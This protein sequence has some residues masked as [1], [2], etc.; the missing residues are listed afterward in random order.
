M[1]AGIRSDLE[2]WTALGAELVTSPRVH[3]PSSFSALLASAV[4]DT[5]GEV[6]VDTGCGAGLVT[7][8]A[9]MADAQH[10]IA[11]DYDAN[12]L[13]D[14][15]ANVERL[16][17]PAARQRLTLWE[18]DWRQ[19]GPMRADV[20]AV[21]PPQRPT[22]LLEDVDDDVLHLHDGGGD[23]GFAG[24]RMVLGHAGT[25]RVRT[26][27]AAVLDLPAAAPDLCGSRWS[28]PSVLTHAHLPLDPAWH[29]L[30]P[31]LIGRVDVWEFTRPPPSHGDG[32][33]TW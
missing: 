27:A 14:T 11:Q 29:R 15:A 17:G 18:A 12:C 24:L 2:R 4:Q 10:V 19:L 3:R 16:L 26:T 7:I 22:A 8:A 13:I 31:E 30:V 5:A 33:L 6:V 9:L 32:T 28:A 21:N 23:D 20:L 1:T 25:P